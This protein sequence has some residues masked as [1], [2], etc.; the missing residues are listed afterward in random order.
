[1]LAIMAIPYAITLMFVM[2]REAGHGPIVA[3]SITK[4]AAYG[5]EVDAVEIEMHPKY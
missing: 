1:M 2:K 4:Q 5:T 3:T